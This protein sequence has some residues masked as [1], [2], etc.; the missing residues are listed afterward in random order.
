MRV[1]GGRTPRV[2]P[3][4]WW[5]VAYGAVGGLGDLSGHVPLRVSAEGGYLALKGV[6][7]GFAVAQ[8]DWTVDDAKRVARTAAWVLV[9]ILGCCAV[10]LVAPGAWT[11]RVLV[12]SLNGG[13]RLG[14]QSLVGPFIHPGSLGQVAALAAIAVFAYRQTHGASSRTTA[15]GLAAAT[16]AALS[17]RRKAVTGMLMGCLV[18][19][20]R[21]R[22]GRTVVVLALTVPLVVVLSWS[23]IAAVVDYTRSEYLGQDRTQVARTVLYS[24]SQQVAREYFPLGAGFGRYGTHTAIAHYSPLYWQ[25]GFDHVYG[26]EPGGGVNGDFASDTFW[27]GV[28]GEAGLFGIVAYV[29]G[30]VALWRRFARYSAAEA[31]ILAWLGLVGL[32]W[33]VEYLMESFA[34]ADYVGPPVYPLLFALGGLACAVAEARPER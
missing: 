20:L 11:S 34:A 15:L 24:T 8:L 7:F 13:Y 26:L 12:A 23:Q 2:P 22:P 9:F 5:F 30:L 6:A 33:S 25:L 10:N 21:R 29:G 3:G 1:V 17:F 31:P 19:A 4:L 14:I 28:L 32:G 16:A 18:M 27:P